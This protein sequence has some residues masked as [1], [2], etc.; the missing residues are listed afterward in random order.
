MGTIVVV[1]P[2]YSGTELAVQLRALA[3]AAAE[4]MGFDPADVKFVLLDLAEQVMPEVGRSWAPRP[5]A[6]CASAASVSGWVS[7]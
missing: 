1:A 4:Q 7:P 3:D 5:C 2:S 6:C